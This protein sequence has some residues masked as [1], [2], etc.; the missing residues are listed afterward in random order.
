MET[1]NPCTS[2]EMNAVSTDLDID[3]MEWSRNA[4]LNNCIRMKKVKPNVPKKLLKRSICGPILDNPL[5]TYV[6]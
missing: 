4:V 6:A 3:L 1:S 5:C 2:G